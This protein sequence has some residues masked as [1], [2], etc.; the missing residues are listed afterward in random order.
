MVKIQMT[1]KF[2]I[3]KYQRYMEIG[4]RQRCLFGVFFF[5]YLKLFDI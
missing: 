3:S 2:Q 4:Y 1:N 5:G